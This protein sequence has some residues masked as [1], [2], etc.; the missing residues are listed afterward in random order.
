VFKNYIELSLKKIGV[1]K[2]DIVKL[3]IY[4]HKTRNIKKKPFYSLKE[5]GK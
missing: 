2:T 5:N 3:P 1:K 4:P